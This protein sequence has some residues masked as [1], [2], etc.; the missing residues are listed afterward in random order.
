[1]KHYDLKIALSYIDKA[2][3]S[4]YPNTGLLWQI[5]ILAWIG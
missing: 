3:S 2:S 4:A 5:V 1:M